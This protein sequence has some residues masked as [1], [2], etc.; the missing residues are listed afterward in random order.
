[1]DGVL[2]Q[3]ALNW[4]AVDKTTNSVYVF[5]EVSGKSTRKANRFSKAHGGRA[6]STATAS[7]N[8]VW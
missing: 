8:R 1:M 4:F 7:P 5:G 2:T 6:N 3:R